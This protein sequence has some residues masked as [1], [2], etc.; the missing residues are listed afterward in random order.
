M[1]EQPEVA[2]A[3]AQLERLLVRRR[4]RTIELL[5]PSLRRRVTP[6]AVSRVR[7]R[8][9]T[10]IE[11]RGKHQLVLLEGGWRLH[12][13]FRMSGDWAWGSSGDEPPRHTRAL[14]RT[15]NGRWVA[16]VDPRALSTLVVVPPDAP[17]PLPPLGPEADDPAFTIAYLAAA[18]AGKRGSLKPALLDQ[19]VLAGVGNIYAAEACW[20]ARIDPRVRAS[21]LGP[22]RL[23]RLIAGIRL[24]LHRGAESAAGYGEA[25][26]DEFAAYGREGERCHRCPGTIR[27]IVQAGRS[28]YFCP[29]CQRP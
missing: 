27:R 18:L 11:R 23:E 24:A 19:R 6:S 9:V 20:H 13:H 21:S 2:R 14:L 28:T 12:V 15:D 16:L 17:S 5:H 3:A 25:A 22:R 7:G 4:I 10:A 8:R 29:R 26:E 1:P